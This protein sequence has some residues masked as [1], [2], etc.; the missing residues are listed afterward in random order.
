MEIP[1]NCYMIF[2]W[3]ESKGE[4][5][6]KHYLIKIFIFFSPPFPILLANSQS[7]KLK[8]QFMLAAVK[9]IALGHFRIFRDLWFLEPYCSLGSVPWA[10]LWSS[11]PY[12]KTVLA[13]KNSKEDSACIGIHEV[14]EGRFKYPFGSLCNFILSAEMPIFFFTF[15]CFFIRWVILCYIIDIS[16]M[17]WKLNSFIVL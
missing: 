9:L 10:W 6:V 17:L 12:F 1:D 2:D 15:S 11:W 16:I 14:L 7:L 3:I 8:G 4:K 13:N 5:Y